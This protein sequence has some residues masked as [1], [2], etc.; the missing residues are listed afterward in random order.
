MVISAEYDSYLNWISS[1]L[2]VGKSLQD[3]ISKTISTQAEFKVKGDAYKINTVEKEM[4]SYEL[5]VSSGGVKP[6]AKDV[7]QC[8]VEDAHKLV[9]S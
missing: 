1:K 3:R 4:Y 2:P 6:E 7:L 5:V 9:G 8:T